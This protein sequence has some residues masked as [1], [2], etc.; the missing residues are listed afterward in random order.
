MDELERDRLREYH[1][2]WYHKNKHRLAANRRKRNKDDY[3]AR[4]DF[5]IKEKIK[6]AKCE[7]CDYPCN[8]DTHMAFDWD[9]LDQSAK[10]FNLGEV[11]GQS[12]KAI[13][14]EI[15]KCQLL[16]KLCHAYKN[17]YERVWEF[18]RDDENVVPMGIDENQLELDL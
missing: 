15:L 18:R 17:Y 8:E 4:K 16:C 6:R 7:E 10:S 13:K 9:H 2:E 11:K 12:F 3:R 14:E 5:I 1:N